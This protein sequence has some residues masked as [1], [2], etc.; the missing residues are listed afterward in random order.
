MALS[1][2]FSDV[3][4]NMTTIGT[5]KTHTTLMV[6][7]DRLLI[8]NRYLQSI[9]RMH[10]DDSRAHIVRVITKTFRICTEL[11]NSYNHSQYLQSNRG[12]S[13]DQLE[14]AEEMVNQVQSVRKMEKSVIEGLQTLSTFKRYTL[15]SSFRIEMDKLVKKMQKICVKCTALCQRFEVVRKLLKPVV[16][17]GDLITL[18]GRSAPMEISRVK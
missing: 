1:T 12:L 7:G 3:E 17:A 14:V 15:D 8:D 5:I 4:W 16:E 13:E 2:V 6:V 11:L 9:F 18:L 10:S